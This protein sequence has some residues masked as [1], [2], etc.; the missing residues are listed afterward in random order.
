MRHVTAG[1]L[2]G[3]VT[4][5]LCFVAILMFTTWQTAALVAVPAGIGLAA[6]FSALSWLSRK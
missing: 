4:A 5:L 1:A 2:V 3:V 6:I